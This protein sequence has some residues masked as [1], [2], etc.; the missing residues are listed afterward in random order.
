[1]MAKKF[2][3]AAELDALEAQHEAGEIS[4]GTYEVRRREILAEVD[5]DMRPTSGLRRVAMVTVALVIGWGLLL[6][7]F[8]LAGG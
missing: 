3:P 2:D 7:V 8:K 1:M 4:T 5:A 6:V